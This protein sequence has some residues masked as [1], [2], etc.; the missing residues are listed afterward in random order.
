MEHNNNQTLESRVSE[1]ERNIELLKFTN[2]I[3]LGDITSAC[4]TIASQSYRGKHLRNSLSGLG[5]PQFLSQ[6]SGGFPSDIQLN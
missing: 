6:Q 1:L 2:C 4:Q 3:A 5:L